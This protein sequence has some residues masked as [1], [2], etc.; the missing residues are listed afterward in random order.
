[1]S[2]AG[3][4]APVALAPPVEPMPFTAGNDPVPLTAGNAPVS[5]PGYAP[6]PP[7]PGK[8]AVPAP[9]AGKE[10]VFSMPG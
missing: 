1:M 2:S 5:V 8:V 7:V 4:N 6:G 10:P 3:G 9:I